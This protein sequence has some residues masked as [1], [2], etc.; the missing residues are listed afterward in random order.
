M[1]KEDVSQP[2]KL[3]TDFGE[4]VNLAVKYDPSPFVR[5]AHGLGGVFA[6]ISNFQASKCDRH[7]SVGPA[8]DRKRI[9]VAK[10]VR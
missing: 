2:L 10:T 6:K 7:A 8:L 1:G 5:R 3:E 4:I 9:E